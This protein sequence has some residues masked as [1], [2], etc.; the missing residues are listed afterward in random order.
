MEPGGGKCKRGSYNFSNA[1]KRSV[2]Y[3][4]WVLS[5]STPSAASEDN[6]NRMHLVDVATP[7][8]LQ[9]TFSYFMAAATTHS[10]ERLQPFIFR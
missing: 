4:G 3:P 6:Y 9:A 8:Q 5:Q 10:D 1:N 7:G 2:R